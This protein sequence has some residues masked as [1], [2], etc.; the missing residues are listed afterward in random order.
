L[1]EGRQ[2]V[3][4]PGAME[5]GVGFNIQ[6]YSIHDGPGIRT[7]VFLK[8]CPLSCWWCHNPESQSATPEVVRV[9]NRCIQCGECTEVC[10]GHGETQRRCVRCGACVQACPTGARQ[11]IGRSMTVDEVLAAVLEDAPFYAESGGGATFSGGEPLT[12]FGFLLSLLRGCRDRGVQTALDTCGYAP[13]DR[14]LQAAALADLVLY[15]LKV[16]DD[17]RHQAFTG[18][19]N[20]LILDNLEALCREHPCIWIRFPVV[21]G[22]ND[23]AAQVEA[24]A[25]FLIGLL[26]VRQVN[27]LPYHETGQHKSKRLGRAI[28]AG[29]VEPPSTQDLDRVAGILRG[30]GL[31][32]QIGG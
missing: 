1:P 3:I 12:Q 28:P 4:L 10:P 5:T 8:G 9:E 31:K 13:Q 27:L 24:L 7:T 2:N 25:Q 30:F 32:T 14:L 23:A 20:A 17:A 15:D 6:K 29:R 11:M 26:G 21:P 22:F 16:M 19:S 18:V